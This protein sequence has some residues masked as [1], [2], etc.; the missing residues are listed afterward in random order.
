MNIDNIA[1]NAPSSILIISFLTSW[2][3]KLGAAFI[4]MTTALILFRLRLKKIKHQ[5]AELERQLIERTEQIKYLTEREQKAREEAELANRAKNQFMARVSHEIRTPLNGIIGM[6]T[7]LTETTLTPEQQEYIETIRGCGDNILTVINDIVLNDI[8]ADRGT[9]SGKAEL[10]EKDFDLEDSV[11]KVLNLFGQKAATTGIELIY[12][13]DQNVPCRIMGDNMRFQQLLTGLL[14]NAFRFTRRGEIHISVYLLKSEEGNV[15]ELGFDVC[16]T[17]SGVP[18][19]EIKLLSGNISDAKTQGSGLT[20][21]ICKRLIDLMG[22]HIEIENRKTGTSVKFSIRT[23]IS[24]QSQ[25]ACLKDDEP[26]LEGK[27]ILIVDDNLSSGHALQ[28]RLQQWKATSMLADSGANALEIMSAGTEYDLVLTD[29]N[30]PGMNGVELAKSMRH[31]RPSL[32]IILLNQVPSE[33]SDY[34]G[35]FTSIM[36]KPVKYHLLKKEILSGLNLEKAEEKHAT[37]QTLSHDFAKTYPMRILIAE[38]NEV[39]QRVAKKVLSKLGYEADIAGNG[40]EV[41]EM[42]SV[43][44]YDLILM[45]VQMPEM[46]GLEATRMIRLCL[47][48]QP[49][50]I[51]ATANSLNGDREGCLEAGM[52]DY[53]SK[54]F[55]LDDLMN[56]IKKWAVKAKARQ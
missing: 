2:W 19:D 33:N 7:L 23:W 24:P 21:V 52:D 32:P 28:K 49:V 42:V 41:L 30:M 37:K 22:G 56:I 39:N 40:K 1:L 18:E 16:D 10:E 17:G 34:S 26:T 31:L 4:V 8:S 6:S 29:M 53:I 9:E 36:S 20:L 25:R 12:T 46:N 5:K 48:V 54:P 3:L 50:I 47:S 44:N 35:L 43:V 11:E 55:Y 27:R 38:D 45:D 51:A 14:D 13:I 15:V